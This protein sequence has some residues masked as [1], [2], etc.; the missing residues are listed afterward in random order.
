[1][2]VPLSLLKEY[3][4]FT[5]TPEELAKVLTEAGIEVEGIETTPL[6]F[7][8]VVVGEVL[9]TAR[10]PSADRLCVAKVSD[11]KEV[12]Q[13]VCG[14]SNCRAGLK[15]AFAKIGAALTDEEGKSF[16]IK[17][18][19]LRDVES[20]GML[21]G[22]D[23]LGLGMGEGIMELT[24]K[25][26]VGTDLAGYYGDVILEVSL[27]PNLGHCMSM[28]GIARELSAQ[29]G[30]P[31]KKPKFAVVEEGDAIEKHLSAALIDQ[32]QCLRYACRGVWGIKVAPS[33]EWLKKKVEACGIRSVNNVVDVG[34]LVMCELGQPLHM[35]DADKISGKK[36]I[37]RSQT[38]FKEMVTLDEVNRPIPEEPLLICDADKPL[39]FAGVM[40]G[41]SS[42]VNEHT[43]NV[44]IEAAVFIPQSIRRTCRWL[45]LKTDSSQR[46]EKGID[47]NAVIEALSY[48]AYLLHKVAGGKVLR[49]AIDHKTHGFDEK[50]IAC[51][52]ERVN[53]LLG[54][55]LSAGEIGSLL[56]RLDMKIVQETGHELIVSVPTYRNDIAIEEDLIEE[57]ARVYGYNNLPKPS[58]LVT[59]STI[60]H[61]PIYLM[62]KQVRQRL[63]GEGL[64]E[65]VNCDLISPAQAEMVAKEAA[66]SVLHAASADQSVLRT[67][68]LPGL[69]Q[70]VKY[71]IDHGTQ[72]IAGF[73]VGRVHFKESEERYV[74]PTA[75][76]IILS[77]K[78]APYHWDP[79]PEEC[80]FFDLKGIVENLLDALKIEGAQFEPSHLHSLHPGRQARIKIGDRVIGVIGEVHPELAAKIDIPQRAFFAELELQELMALV[81]KQTKV[82]EVPQFPGSERDW[83]VTLN[84]HLP[85]EEILRSLR[86]VPSRLLESVT[87]LDLY[88]S[89]Q[90]GKDK[91][92]ATFRFYYRDK[93]KTIAYETVEQEH[94]RITE[95]A[96]KKLNG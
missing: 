36:I 63:I 90:I 24:E 58:P 43:V 88:K 23:E 7:S 87:L 19:K 5:Q 25:F 14:A 89:E 57:V 35:F 84:E 50:K 83:T 38:E 29:L 85:I 33:P 62:E 27:T 56:N 1:M 59:N 46:F 12:F 20:F 28:L 76:G 86:S 72:N 75:A 40:G 61:A 39:A 10:H 21:C 31:I 13:V 4:N 52:P 9:E 82:E 96:A 45:G 42:A 71:N 66:V 60:P 2:K 95:A 68:L 81:P 67:S 80:D 77:G 22:A 54:T 41:K 34:N 15:T 64:Q 78:R 70:A 65:M 55:A 94:T 3:L 48:A 17:K 51:R 30:I 26:V 93:E 69:L 49:G 44:A 32:R 73:E 18:G 47:P 37:I 53:K 8:G 91:K 11:G 92:N 74:E 79:K 16:K 6:K